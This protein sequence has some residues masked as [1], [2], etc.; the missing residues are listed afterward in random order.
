MELS[1]ELSQEDRTALYELIDKVSPCVACVPTKIIEQFKEW[2]EG[3]IKTY[4]I[5]DNN[6][7]LSDD[8]IYLI[9]VES[10]K[11]NKSSHRRRMK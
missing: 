9:P 1:K 11:I 2:T 3:K 6:I 10:S 5:P 7:F 4:E 8:K